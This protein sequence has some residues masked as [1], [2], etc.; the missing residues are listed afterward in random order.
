VQT[1]HLLRITLADPSNGGLAFAVGLSTA[2]TNCTPAW[3]RSRGYG[4]AQHEIP[5]TG[6][7]ACPGWSS[8]ACVFFTMVMWRLR[9]P[10]RPSPHQP[11]RLPTMSIES[12]TGGTKSL[13]LHG[14]PLAHGSTCDC[15][16]LALAIGVAP[17]GISFSYCRNV[18]QRR[19][20]MCCKHGDTCANRLQKTVD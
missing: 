12:T 18:L 3:G 13:H 5:L 15:S 9:C 6:C 16:L 17:G 2:L 4:A 19:W 7:T 14:V 8:A 1:L 20:T 10:A 11:E